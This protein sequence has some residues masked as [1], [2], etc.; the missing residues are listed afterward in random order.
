MNKTQIIRLV[1]SII[2]L[3]AYPQIILLEQKNAAG[4]LTCIAERKTTE[5]TI[6]MIKGS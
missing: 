5:A 2:V 3:Y 4:Q 6:D 1:L